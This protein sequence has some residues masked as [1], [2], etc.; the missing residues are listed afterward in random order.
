MAE[1]ADAGDSKSPEGN[2][3]WVR[4]PL[5]ALRYLALAA[6]AACAAPTAPSSPAPDAGLPPFVVPA[7]AREFR[8][9]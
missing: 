4:F 8:G 9:M 2:L 6:L 5:R 7:I 1:P 3:M